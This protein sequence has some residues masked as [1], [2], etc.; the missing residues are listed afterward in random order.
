MIRNN[1]EFIRIILPTL[2]P[3]TSISKGPKLKTETINM[4]ESVR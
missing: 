3:K 1:K 2:K 4:L